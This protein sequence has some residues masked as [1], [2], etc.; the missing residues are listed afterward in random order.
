MKTPAH[1]Q[2]CNKGAEAMPLEL[3]TSVARTF[4]TCHTIFRHLSKV[5]PHGQLHPLSTSPLPRVTA[6]LQ[7]DFVHNLGRGT[8]LLQQLLH[9]VHVGRH[10]FEEPT[11]ASAQV[12]EAGIAVTVGHKAVL[13]ALPVARE[14]VL[15]LPA[16]PG[17]MLLFKRCE[18][19]L[20][21]AVH[22]LEQ[23]L[24]VD[25]AQTVLRE[26]EMI[27]AVH[28][29]VE[30][31]CSRMAARFAHGTDA[32][33][34]PAPVCQGGIEELDEHFAHVVAHPLV[35]DS[36]AEAAPLVGRYAEIGHRGAG[37]ICEAGQMAA[38]GMAHDALH[39]GRELDVLA[40]YLLEETVELERVIGVEVVDHGH[41][42]P[43]HAV[44][45]QQ[46]DARHDLR[47]RR[48]PAAAAAVLVVKLL[49]TVYTHAHQPVVLAE[50]LAPLIGQQGAVC[51]YGIGY[52][53][54]PGVLALQLQSPLVEGERA[55]E[56]LSAVPGKEHF[57]HGLRLDI[58]LGEAL[59]QPVAHHVARL[60][61]VQMGFLEIVTVRASQV[62][63]GPDG[64]Q[65]D[66]HGVRKEVEG[67][68][69]L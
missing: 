67:G 29:A 41:C 65:H 47:P 52:H 69:C 6:F 44:L 4:D 24:R 9:A 13:G 57:V 32:G 17:Q 20:L 5:P 26:H 66:V 54:A 33:G 61:V 53:A 27:A 23:R 34:L 25:V 30:L 63:V 50:E 39:D 3:L 21:V 68:H 37:C 31:H 55:H 10:V 48:F 64:L 28:V 36:T 51:L 49:R 60:L 8:L 2:L 1:Q 22:H 19:P 35:E 15:A 43:L 12:V 7:P 16:L 45:L 46:P 38:V 11:V 62:A 58:L 56:R 42:I 18:G 40:A 14:A 59:E